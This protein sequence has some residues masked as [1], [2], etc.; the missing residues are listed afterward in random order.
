[1]R[2]Y[3]IILLV[4]STLFLSHNL[5]GQ[6]AGGQMSY[7]TYSSL[8]ESGSLPD[9]SNIEVVYPNS[10]GSNTEKDEP[11]LHSNKA[12]SS[13]YGYFPPNSGATSHV[14]ADDESFEVTLSFNFCFYGQNYTSVY[15]NDNGN[16]TF[17]AASGSF[18]STGFPVLFDKM[19]APFWADFHQGSFGGNGVVWYENTPT[20][21][22][23]HWENIGYYLNGTNK[24]NT[25]MLIITDG[26]DPLLASGNNVGFFYDDMQWTTGEAS[27]GTNGFGGTASTVGINKGDG[28]TFI[29]IGRFDQPGS[30]Y[31]GAYGNPD[32]VDWLDNKSLMFDVCNSTNI[33]PI[34]AGVS[35]CDTIYLCVGDTMPINFSVISGESGQTTEV[36]ID[37]SAL[38]NYTLVSN[39]PGNTATVTSYLIGDTSNIGLN[40]LSVMAFDNGIPADTIWFDLLVSVDTIPFHPVITG[41][42]V[43]CFGEQVI[44]Q[45]TAG[46]ETYDWNNGNTTS[47]IIVGGGDYSLTVS[48]RECYETTPVFHVE[49]L[50]RIIPVIQGD[51]IICLTGDPLIDVVVLSVDGSPYNSMTWSPGNETTDNITVGIGTYFVT[52]TDTSGCIEI[53]NSVNVTDFASGIGITGPS[54]Y[55]QGDSALLDAGPGFDSYLWQTGNP[56]DTLQTIYAFEGTYTVTITDS[57]CVGDVSHTLTEVAEI[58]PVISGDPTYCFGEGPSTL[59][60]GATG[61]SSFEWLPNNETTTSINV[62]EGFYQVVGSYSVCKDTSVV[63]T[64]TEDDPI[65]AN[66]QTTGFVCSDD[67]TSVLAGS[68]FGSYNWDNGSTG[69]P[70]YFYQGGNYTLTV[71]NASNCSY[72]TTITILDVTSPSIVGDNMTCDGEYQFTSNFAPQGVTWTY[73]GP[74][75][76]TFLN[77]MN[78]INPLI[79]ANTNGV[80]SLTMSDDKCLRSITHQ[81]I[82]EG[83]P[84][85]S[86]QDEEICKDDEL[87]FDVVQENLSIA[88]YVWNT[89]S[90]DAIISVNSEISAW[91][92]V[93]ING[94]CGS[95]KDSAFVKVYN[96]E[97][98]NVITPN[99]DNQNDYFYTRFAEIYNDVSLTIFNRWGKII[100]END[101]YDNSWRGERM[102]SNQ[103]VSSGTYYYLMR[104]DSGQQEATG[105]VTVFDSK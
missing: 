59:T 18:T 35:V 83:Y 67:S 32:G 8:K 1:M 3:L 77:S 100:Y 102:D 52:T 89:G 56:G 94:Y 73:S 43:V 105:T 70:V 13:C 28:T 55:C 10:V 20:A 26:L 103:Q 96:C 66:V 4:Y 16:I 69:N 98:P 88:D 91:Y 93:E 5:F 63:F 99:G 81:I 65:Y 44:L 48:I 14:L 53:S 101:T 22:I 92:V 25:M 50:P 21:L 30:A 79:T 17:D 78:D 39:I 31:D 45:S 60:V 37:S 15:I 54:L 90:N 38:S 49:E 76:L 104:W 33:P 97:I 46:F 85:V 71:V 51:S 34:V 11:V 74:G 12:Q 82:F 27:G 95:V 41:D 7:E 24:R 72:D 64:V 40:V 62:F 86:L 36:V 58:I 57:T 6:E 19:I 61:F 29:Q 75:T 68:G 23:V 47:D 42:S 9:M 80:Y 87:K 84:S 2:Y